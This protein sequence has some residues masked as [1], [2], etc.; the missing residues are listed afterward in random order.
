MLIYPTKA[1]AQDQFKRLVQYLYLINEK[2]PSSEQ[3]TIGIY[4]GDTPTNV[5]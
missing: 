1:L 3:I 2:W 5:G 4:D